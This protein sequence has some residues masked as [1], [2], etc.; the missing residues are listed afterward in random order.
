[1][2]EKAKH[3]FKQLMVILPPFTVCF[4]QVFMTYFFYVACL[5]IYTTAAHFYNTLSELWFFFSGRPE[6]HKHRV[7][8]CEQKK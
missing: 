4:V 8:A 6:G 5:C 1:M 7:C 3:I 2:L